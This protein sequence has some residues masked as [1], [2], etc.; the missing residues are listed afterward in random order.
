MEGGLQEHQPEVRHRAAQITIAIIIFLCMLVVIDGLLHFTH[1]RGYLTQ[2]VPPEY[3]PRD[4]DVLFKIAPNFPTTTHHMLD[5]AY[6]FWSNSRGCF[7]REHDPDAVTVY[8]TGDSFTWGFTPLE[9]KWTTKF[10]EVFDVPVAKYGVLRYRTKQELEKSKDDLADFTNTKLIVLAYYE[11]DI[12]DDAWL[13]RERD[14][15]KEK[16]FSA[17]SEK[18]GPSRWSG[19]KCFLSH[20]SILYVFSY[21]L[22]SSVVWN[23]LPEPYASSIVT[24]ISP[25][26]PPQIKLTK[27]D[28]E[29]HR[30]NIREFKKLADEHDAVLLILR[31]PSKEEIAGGAT[32]ERYAGIRSNIEQV[33][34]EERIL[35]FDVAPE[36][37]RYSTNV[38]LYWERDLHLNVAGNRILGLLLSRFV[39]EQGLIPLVNRDAILQSVREQLASITNKDAKSE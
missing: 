8:I 35:Y 32:M 14:G 34:Q 17:C 1:L 9:D 37:D 18:S 24:F 16:T 20:N 13:L 28:F 6:P 4:S 21:S 39:A 23:A 25:T 11:N 12:F 31:I 15:L 26:F 36:L 22:L 3:A 7:D 5:A 38:P 30:N 27:Q 29:F 33:L 2:T 19:V 10:G